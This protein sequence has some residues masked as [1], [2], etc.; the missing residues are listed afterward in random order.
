[1][2]NVYCF[3]VAAS[4]LLF[5]GCKRDRA[6]SPV[7]DHTSAKGEEGNPILEANRLNLEQPLVQAENLE[8]IYRRAIF[9]FADFEVKNTPAGSPVKDRRLGQLRDEVLLCDDKGIDDFLHLE[10][11]QFAG[12]DFRTPLGDHLLNA[13]QSG[14]SGMKGQGLVIGVHSIWHSKS[15]KRVQVV[16]GWVSTI[17][18]SWTFLYEIDGDGRMLLRKS[19]NIGCDFP[20]GW[21]DDPRF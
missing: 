16:L 7:S 20:E 14:S 13:V 5:A 17:G 18:E 12:V 11:G 19:M 10:P 15:R 21:I 6:E 9:D 1:M 4:V 3:L 2:N 8:R